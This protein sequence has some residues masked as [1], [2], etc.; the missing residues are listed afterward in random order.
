[1]KESRL[2]NIDYKYPLIENKI[3]R[4]DC[5]KFLEERSFHNIKKSSCTFCPF[6]SNR[7]WKELKQNYPDEW[8]K[9][10]QVDK[11]IRD[12]SQKGLK[13]KLYLHRSLKPIDEA[14]LQEDQEELFMCEEGYCG[15]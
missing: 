15:I 2:Y 8:A 4:G 12:K 11:A 13:D 14:Y 10:V 9:V 1:M 3:T 7:Q 5:I 6:H